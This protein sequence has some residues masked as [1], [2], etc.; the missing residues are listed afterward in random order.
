MFTI[1]EITPAPWGY[2]YR[3]VASFDRKEDAEEVLTVLHRVTAYNWD[4]YKIFDWSTPKGEEI[5]LCKD[6]M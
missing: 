2:N 3:H 6:E 4:I 5:K 1:E